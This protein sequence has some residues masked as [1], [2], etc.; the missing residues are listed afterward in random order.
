LTSFFFAS[1][2]LAQTSAEISPPKPKILATSLPHRDDYEGRW[3]NSYANKGLMVQF[4]LETI[5]YI[6]G[7]KVIPD[8]MMPIILV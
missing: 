4:T 2:N 7:A 8:I 6:F 5:R 3:V 1:Q